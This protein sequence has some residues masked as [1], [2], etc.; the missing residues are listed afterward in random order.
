[1]PNHTD[2]LIMQLDLSEP[3]IARI[4][5]QLVADA[6]RDFRL[7]PVRSQA[8]LTRAIQIH[9][10]K[11]LTP[12]CDGPSRQENKVTHQELIKAADKLVRAQR[13]LEGLS[14]AADS[15]VWHYTWSAWSDAP[16]GEV[17]GSAPAYHSLQQMREAL[18]D[19]ANRLRE[20]AAELDKQGP[21]WRRAIEREERIRRAHYLAPVFEEAFE[22]EASINT[23]GG[24]PTL[25]LWP[26]FYQRIVAMAFSE[27][28][29]PDLVPVLKEARRRHVAERAVFDLGNVAD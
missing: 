21:N 4:T 25:G 6:L 12:A 28:A 10:R 26:D 27:H 1:M 2:D 5:E 23:W 15:A 13:A 22:V 16:V 11:S 19:H 20:A 14:D 17:T 24:A 3:R 8:W 7:T 29:T 18:D 9:L